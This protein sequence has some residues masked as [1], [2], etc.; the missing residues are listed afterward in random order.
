MGYDRSVKVP[1]TA[2][3][4]DTLLEYVAKAYQRWLRPQCLK[5]MQIEFWFYEQVYTNTGRAQSEGRSSD[6]DLFIY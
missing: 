6:C 1:D 4:A 2:T 3:V 5:T